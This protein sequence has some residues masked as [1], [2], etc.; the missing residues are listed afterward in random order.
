MFTLFLLAVTPVT[1]LLTAS[2]ACP[3]NLAKTCALVESIATEMTRSLAVSELAVGDFRVESF[4]ASGPVLRVV[5][6][7]TY[8][9]SEFKKAFAAPGR[10]SAEYLGILRKTT[11]Q[12]NC[13]EP[14]RGIVDGGGSIVVQILFK[15]GGILDAQEI[16]AC[17]ELRR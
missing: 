9:E 7:T 1:T 3:S 16:S 12:I 14:T 11:L 2:G 6:R 15:D 4:K 13:L 17:P 8:T 10:S 5:Q